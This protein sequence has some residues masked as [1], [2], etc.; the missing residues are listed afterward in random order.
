MRTTLTR[1]AALATAAVAALAVTTPARAGERPWTG[2]W[3]AAV[4]QPSPGGMPGSA[5][6]SEAGFA[7]HSVRQVVRLS[8][9]G[10]KLRI[11]LS[12]RYGTTPLTVTGVTV[13]KAGDGAAVRPLT[14]R[15]VTFGHG[16]GTVIPAGREAVS[17]AVA[18][19]TAALDRLSVTLY[20]RGSTGPASFHDIASAT[21]YRARGDHRFDPRPRAFTETSSSWYYLTGVDVLGDAGSVVTFGDSVTDGTGSTQDAD[22]RYPDQL[23]ERLAASGSRLGV[24]N[25]GLSGNRLLNDSACFGE[26]AT[27]RFQRDVLDRPGV[28]SVIVMAGINDITYPLM[29]TPCSRPNPAVTAEQIIEGHRALIRAARARGVKVIGGT[30]MPFKGNPWLYPEDN[31]QTLAME[32]TRDAVNQW[33]RS[34]GEYDAVADFERVLADPADPDRLRPE[35][36]TRDGQEGDWLHPNDAGLD[37]MARAIDLAT[38]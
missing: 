24:L 32:R 14:L 4:Q 29:D 15:P 6:W 18:L 7:D 2:T 34:G 5:N 10:A 21:V 20:V 37:A 35:Y 3:A 26:K 8:T 11:R 12:N 22:N 28:R 13:G 16:R 33:I 25:A 38:L 1:A 31:A 9:G 17:D 30:I 23:A 36:N 27:A 19:P